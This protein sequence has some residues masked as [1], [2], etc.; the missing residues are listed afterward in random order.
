MS[1]NGT[2]HILNAS[3]KA[4]FMKVERM[5]VNNF[6]DEFGIF[7]K[8][9]ADVRDQAQVLRKRSCTSYTDK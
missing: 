7:T 2:I 9:L 3:K 5:K 4:T 8:I 6:F 1:E